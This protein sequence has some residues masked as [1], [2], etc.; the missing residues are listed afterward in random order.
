MSGRGGR[1]AREPREGLALRR[2]LL[3]ASFGIAA[4]AVLGRAFQ[5]QALEGEKW[6]A[7]AADQQQSR[8]PVPARRGGIFDR[9]GTPLALSYETFRIS[10]A[11]REL[12][13]RERAAEELRSAL[14][15]SRSAARRATDPRRRWVVLPGRFT[16]EQHQRVRGT[17]GIHSE[18]RLERFYP[19]GDVGREV[20]GVV[21][22]DGRALGG[23]EQEMDEL[24]RGADGYALMRRDARGRA[25]PTVSLPVVPPRDGA[26]VYLTL[27]F[28][29]QE[30]ADGALRQ[31][32]R[33][34]GAAGG[35]LLVA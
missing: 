8:V 24:L 26:D 5:L 11:P 1:G 28:D 32:L 16:A 22:A 12:R 21:S 3:A 30:I 10:V 13:D 15:L 31:A 9:N 4:A 33:S 34:T 27:D 23:A 25:E 18:R 19:Q 29:L 2:R 17:R 20:L 7:V 14:G 6:A 35:D